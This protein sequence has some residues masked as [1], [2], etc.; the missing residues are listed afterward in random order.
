MS[1]VER[2]LAIL[3]LFAATE[4]ESLGVTEIAGKTGLSKAVVHRILSSLR[5]HG[6]VDADEARRYRLGTSVLYLGLA[7]LDR[8]D[9]RDLARPV[10][11]KLSRTTNETSTI[12]IRNGPSRVYIDQVTPDR[13]V[14]MVVQ[15]GRPWPLHAGASSKAFLA[16]LDDEQINEYLRGPLQKLTPS[17]VTSQRALRQEI[18]VIRRKGYATSSGE[19]LEGAASVAA[20]VFG[21]DGYPSAVI[22]VS[23][24]SE[25]LKKQL[26]KIAPLVVSASAD[27]SKRLGH[28]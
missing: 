26:S 18:A 15:L 8:L 10:L 24:P 12:S 2:A 14:K 3:D 6:Y 13:D 4:N 5:S 16:F 25:R 22:S 28:K 17:T 20:P 23:G 21:R 27:L 11:E 7:Y 19:R 1:T 9:V